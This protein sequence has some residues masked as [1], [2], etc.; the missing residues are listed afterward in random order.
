[1]LSRNEFSLTLSKI[2]TT[3]TIV[4]NFRH[5][6]P[7]GLKIDV[8]S[9][10]DTPDEVG[11]IWAW[12]DETEDPAWP[13]VVNVICS[14]EC[15]LGAYPDLRLAEELSQHSGCQVL[16]ETYPFAG[17]LDPH[18]PYWALAYVEGQWYLADT[19]NTPL[20]GPDMDGQEGTGAVKLVRPITIPDIYK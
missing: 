11:A 8:F 20:M 15:Q 9:A 5:L 18:D 3:D 14:Q 17:D 10:L 6:I 12:L 1:M 13:C 7:A 2:L 19:V 16:T 4:A